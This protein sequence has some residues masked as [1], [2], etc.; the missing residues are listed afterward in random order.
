MDQENKKPITAVIV[1]SKSDF[2]QMVRGLSLLEAESQD[3]GRVETLGV[4]VR[5][6]HRHPIA[7]IV[8]IYQ[9][10]CQDV[11][12]IITGAG[13]LN[14]L[15]GMV[16][17][18]LLR[19]F[20]PLSCALSALYLWH[21]TPEQILGVRVLA[22]AF[23]GSTDSAN[24]AAMYGATEVPGTQL[25]WKT[26]GT[27]EQYVGEEGFFN[28]VMA[29]VENNLPVSLN[30]PDTSKVPMDFTVEEALAKAKEAKK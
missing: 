4:F 10:L 1:G 21:I 22:V 3:G 18:I 25:V 29:V 12:V 26:P 13:K 23:K 14:A 27:D 24:Q 17:T 7:L 30:P 16:E 5:S 28:A 11:N 15:S 6:C 9:L 2:E 19:I 20:Y 8:L